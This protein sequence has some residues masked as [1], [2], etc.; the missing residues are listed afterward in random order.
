MLL[1][2]QNISKSFG[3]REIFNIDKIE[4]NENSRIGLVGYNG[5]GK[6][7]LLNILYGIA[8]PDE[9]TI[10]RTCNIAMINQFGESDGKSDKQ[11]L[12]KMNLT[13]S[14]CLSG[15]ERTRLAIASAF[16][17]NTSL[18]L[19]DEPTTNLDLDGIETVQ[20]MFSEYKGAIVLVS[21]DR[22]LIDN[23]CNTIWEL[24]NGKLRC[25][26]GN[27]SGWLEQKQKEYD[28]AIFE[29][30]QYRSEKKR[31]EIAKIQTHQEAKSMLKTPK[32]MGISEARLHRNTAQTSQ[33]HVESRVK[34]MQSRLDKI[35]VKER[36]IDLP[37]I[38][39]DLGVKTKVISKIAAQINNLT[40]K[41]NNHIVLNSSSFKLPTGKCTV[42]LGANGTGKTT[43]IEHLINFDECTTISNGVK[44]GYFSQNHEILDQNKT[45]LENVRS[46]SEMAEYDV[47]SILANLYLKSDDIN[48]RANLLSGGERAKVVFAQLLASDANLLI[49]DEPTNHIDIYTTEALEKLLKKWKGTMLIV[50]HDRQLTEKIADRLL[51]VENSTV[52]TF[53]GTWVEYQ[54]KNYHSDF[55]ETILSMRLTELSARINSPKK[56]DDIELLNKELDKIVE[57]YKKLRSK[58]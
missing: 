7:T 34:A 30:E 27:Y 14:S 31:L 57:E 49:L 16:S 4:I 41:Y 39:M 2:A 12:S 56:N 13:N 6:S 20:K 42:M 52:K 15:G 28:F 35:E 3:I 37:E 40:V 5:A 11:L 22:K 24:E 1:Q 29:Y 36:P 17:K 51:F 23:I 32:R 26:C 44:I 45:V 48:K 43:L 46:S 9:G 55:D 54:Q 50:T 58:K 33:S 10:K 25:F 53:E 18:I 38:K 21:H 19:A 8:K 47:R